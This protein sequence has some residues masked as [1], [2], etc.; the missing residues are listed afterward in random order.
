MQEDVLT[1]AAAT[2]AT[3]EQLACAGRVVGYYYRLELPP[4]VQQRFDAMQEARA[5]AEWAARARTCCQREDCSV[6]CR[7]MRRASRTGPCSVA[8]SNV[9]AGRGR[10]EPSGGAMGFTLSIRTG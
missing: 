10:R 7:N 1:A 9:Y 5:S 4:G 6:A 8:R 3:E 2:A